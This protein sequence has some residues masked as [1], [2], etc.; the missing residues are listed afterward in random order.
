[1]CCVVAL[2]T[3]V[4]VV[5][6]VVCLFVCYRVW[7]WLCVWGIVF[8]LSVVSLWDVQGGVARISGNGT[9]SAEHCTFSQNTA[10]VSPVV[11]AL[12]RVMS[13]YL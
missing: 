8:V 4:V 11:R 6:F 12:L 1:M 13:Q 9:F 5:S 3:L 7:A 10:G 2:L